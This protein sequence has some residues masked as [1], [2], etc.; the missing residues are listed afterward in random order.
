VAAR[1][2]ASTMEV[3]NT[4]PGTTTIF[5]GAFNQL[6]LDPTDDFWNAPA[7][8][9]VDRTAYADARFQFSAG[10]CR[11]CHGRETGTSFLQI[12]PGEVGQE[13]GLSAF[14][15]GAVQVED[16][17]VPGLFR[18]LDEM[19]R[20]QNDL[21]MV[22]NG[23]AVRVPVL[24]NNYTVRFLNGVNRCLDSAGNTTANGAFSQLFDCH[25]MA[26]QRLSLV[27]L[28]NQ[29]FSLKYKHSGKCIDVQ[30]GATNGGARVCKAPAIARGPV[31]D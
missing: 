16:P 20:R 30:N 23:D 10:T 3:P 28:G 18:T 2:I 29:L 13:P 7:P 11:G 12:F 6:G 19:G 21:A 25:G 24:G 4:F 26:N 8:A 14:L 1:S 27:S 5:R 22:V 31:R 17:V 9:G 15:S